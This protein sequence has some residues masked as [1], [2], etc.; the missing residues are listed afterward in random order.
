[1]PGVAP[2]VRAGRLARPPRPA[3]RRGRP[4]RRERRRD[5]VLTARRSIA[6]EAQS[7]FKKEMDPNVSDARI[8]E[9]TDERTPE[10]AVTPI[11]G[12]RARR[13]SRPAPSRRARRRRPRARPRASHRTACSPAACAPSAQRRDGPPERVDDGHGDRAGLG[14]RVTD[15][16]RA[17]RPG[18][19]P[20]AE[21]RQRARR[22]SDA[23]AA[24][25]CPSRGPERRRRTAA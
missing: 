23:V 4:P 5:A 13:T 11:T 20:A 14:E 6:V 1:M 17:P 22:G 9:E 24:P 8:L 10:S 25:A 3:R 2:T 12:R 21:S 16:R 15:G 7:A 19:A 18:S